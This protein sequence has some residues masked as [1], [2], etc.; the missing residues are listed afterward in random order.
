MLGDTGSSRTSG[1]KDGVT[2]RDLIPVGTHT[3][4]ANA[5]VVWK[6]G[7]IDWVEVGSGLE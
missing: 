2:N 5:E 6:V 3:A 4:V 7:E 1:K